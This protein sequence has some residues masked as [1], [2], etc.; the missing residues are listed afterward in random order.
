MRSAG[1]GELLRFSDWN[2]TDAQRIG[3]A[4]AKMKPRASMPA[5]TS[6]PASRQAIRKRVDDAPERRAV[7][8][9]RRDVVEEYAGLRKVWPPRG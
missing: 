5:I 7:L 3:H 4:G 8:Q 6:A 2:E 1:A 9:K